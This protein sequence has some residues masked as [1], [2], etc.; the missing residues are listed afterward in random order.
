M[1]KIVSE[2]NLIALNSGKKLLVGYLLA[3]Y[4]K[5]EQFLKLA[6][7]CETAGLDIFEIGFPSVDPFSDGEVIR[8]A[9]NMVDSSICTDIEY[10]KSIRHTISKPIWLMGYKR[11]LM[12]TGFYRILAKMGLMDALVIPDISFKDRL[13]LSEELKGYGVDI[14]GFVNPEMQVSELEE[15]FSST[16]L[17]YQQ[18]HTGQ[19]GMSMVSDGYAEILNIARK[20]E[21]TK[22]FAGF[23]IS[24]SKQVSQLV[25]EGFDGVILGTAM[26]NK[27]NE[28][29][30]E[31]LAFVKEL[32][33]STK[34]AGIEN[35]VHSNF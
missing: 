24:T 25:G 34:K 5:K 20:Y 21:H 35:E 14:V 10:W 30:Q 2:R 15:C 13:E 8:K 19:T 4:P 16:A 32:V 33:N 6:A 31:L 28:S 23:G 12:D 17:I 22:V 26:I 27:L 18:L 9:H 29:K 3:G 11:D 1:T 7:D